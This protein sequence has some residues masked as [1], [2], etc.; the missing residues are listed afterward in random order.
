MAATTATP[1]WWR[2]DKL[3][4]ETVKTATACIELCA[5][6]RFSRLMA[7][8]AVPYGFFVLICLPSDIDH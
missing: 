4:G 8:S 6:P 5:E 2:T 7:M 3:H 1:P